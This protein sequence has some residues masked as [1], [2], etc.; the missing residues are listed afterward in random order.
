[1]QK[2]I[3]LFNQVQCFKKKNYPENPINTLG[4][5]GSNHFKNRRQNDLLDTAEKR[6]VR[7]QV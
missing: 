3:K 6:K 5:Y 2:G 7:H 4:K 1:M